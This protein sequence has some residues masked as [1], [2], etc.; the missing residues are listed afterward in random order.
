MQC[1][2]LIRVPAMLKLSST[3]VVDIV[4]YS[5]QLHTCCIYLI[6]IATREINEFS[7]YIFFGVFK[8]NNSI[9]NALL[10]IFLFILIQAHKCPREKSKRKKNQTNFTSDRT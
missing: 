4:L 1:I 8:L 3:Y 6:F 2:C 9:E 7:I 10:A 5:F